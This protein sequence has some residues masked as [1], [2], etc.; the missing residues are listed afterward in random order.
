[1]LK[2]G[3][4]T[5]VDLDEKLLS[6]FETLEGVLKYMGEKKIN[7]I[8]PPEGEMP[9]MPADISVL[10][11]QDMGKLYSEILSW[12]NFVIT[13]LALLH[14]EHVQEKNRLSYVKARLKKDLGKTEEV[15]AHPA[16]LDARVRAQQ[17]EQKFLWVEAM[18]K[19]LNKNLAVVSRH[20]ELRKVDMDGHVREAGIS[21]GRGAARPPKS[22]EEEDPWL[23]RE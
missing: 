13:E 21:K 10:S 8:Q 2:A 22:E 15:E 1:M 18:S 19:V 23:T 9:T 11:N 7:P 16:M 6:G 14:A 3:N 20:I 17:S 5:P 4:D 12:H